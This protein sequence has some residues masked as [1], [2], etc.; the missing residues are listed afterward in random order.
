MQKRITKKLRQALRELRSLEPT[1]VPVVV[2]RL[3]MED[4]WGLCNLRKSKSGKPKRFEITIDT[5]IPAPFV[6]DTLIHEW[7]HAVAWQEGKAVDDH[8]PEWAI[9]FSRIYQQMVGV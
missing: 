6:V 1:L 4:C 2:R 7:A 3:P 8:G 9:A 5:S